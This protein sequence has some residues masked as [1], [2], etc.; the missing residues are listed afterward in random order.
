[1]DSTKSPV[2]EYLFK[3]QMI[4]SNTTFKNK[5]EAEK[6]ETLEMSKVANAY[7]AAVNNTD[8]FS[9]YTYSQDEVVTVLLQHNKTPEQIQFMLQHPH[10]ISI[11]IQRELMKPHHDAVIENYKEHNRYYL[12]L[13]GLPYLEGRDGQND[14]V[15]RIPDEFYHRYSSY[16]ELSPGTPVYELSPEFQEIYIN[17]EFYQ[18][19]LDKYPHLDYL[20]HIGSNSIPLTVSRPTKDG[21]IMNINTTKLSTYHP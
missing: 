1:M 11:D 12:N 5:V 14:P 21:H 19:A 6:Y 16:P 15:I 20:R 4:V 2:S 7:L 9:S 13:M 10:T 18:Q 3:L 8:I 17:S